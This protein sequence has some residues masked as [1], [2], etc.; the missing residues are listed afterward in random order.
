MNLNDILMQSRIWWIPDPMVGTGG[1]GNDDDDPF[2]ELEH[3]EE[4]E[5]EWSGSGVP[6]GKMWCKLCD[7]D[8]DDEDWQ[9]PFIAEN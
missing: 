4:C 7:M 8:R 5:H 1:N 3:E 9:L 2:K 6:G